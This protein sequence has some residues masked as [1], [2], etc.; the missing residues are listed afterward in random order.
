MRLTAKKIESLVLLQKLSQNSK[1][2][3]LKDTRWKM[4]ENEEMWNYRNTRDHETAFVSIKM[5]LDRSKF[6]EVW[7]VSRTSRREKEGAENW[8][9]IY[10]CFFKGGNQHWAIEKRLLEKASRKPG[11]TEQSKELH[12]L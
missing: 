6:K 10:S 12:P 1:M 2:F 11:E 8:E 4:W 5:C 3:E 7:R 9:R